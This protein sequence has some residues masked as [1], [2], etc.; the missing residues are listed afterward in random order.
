MGARRPDQDNGEASDFDL[1][2]SKAAQTVMR[3]VTAYPL[4]DMQLERIVKL[5]LGKRILEAAITTAGGGPPRAA[6]SMARASDYPRTGPEAMS[7][8][9]DE[10]RCADSTEP[11][12]PPPATRMAR[13]AT[14]STEEVA[15]GEDP[16]T[17]AAQPP[18]EAPPSATAT[19]PSGGRKRSRAAKKAARAAAEASDATPAAGGE[20]EL[21]QEE[22]RQCPVFGCTRGHDPG[23]CPTFLDMTPKERLDMIHAKQLCLL[24]L[25]HPLSVG[26]EAAGKGAGCPM[27]ECDRPHH[28]ALHEVLKAGGSSSPRGKVDPPGRPAVPMDFGA[29]EMARLRRHFRAPTF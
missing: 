27:G 11:E 9:G 16:E 5:A 25:R 10:S 8:D 2:D 28:A 14:P 6:A 20:W 4:T 26:C 29:P 23:D 13:P 7:D 21:A 1:A 22:P 3:A 18:G 15:A 17:P 24:C 19:T 12:G